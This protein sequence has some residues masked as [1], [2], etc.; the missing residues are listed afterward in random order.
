M[1]ATSPLAGSHVLVTGGAGFHL[2]G[3]PSIRRSFD[4]PAEYV[5]VQTV[6][7]PFSIYGPGASPKSVIGQ[8]IRLCLEGQPVALED[9]RPVRDYCFAEDFALEEGLRITATEVLGCAV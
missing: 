7:R 3:I 2:G 5:R 1:S 4:H 8:I 9:L 6:L